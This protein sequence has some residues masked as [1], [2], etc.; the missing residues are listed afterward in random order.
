M[1][2]EIEQDITPANLDSTELKRI[3]SG[4]LERY[5][6]Y[7]RDRRPA[8]DQWLRNLRQYLGEYDPEARSQ[9]P[10]GKSKAYPK[11]TRMKVVGMVSK[12]MSM[13][14][15]EGE[16][17][18]SVEAS[19][20]PSVD[21]D[22]LEWIIGEWAMDNPEAQ[23]DLES[24]ES[25]IK[26]FADKAAERMTTKVRDQLNDA[27]EHGQI[28]YPT[29]ARKVV[30]SAVLYSM[31]VLKGPMTIESKGTR[32]SIND[33]NQVVISDETVYRPYFSFVRLWDYY[34]DMMAPSFDAMDGQF[35]R[36]IMSKHQLLRL[37][38]RD[39][40]MSDAI[41]EFVRQNP[42]GNYVAL[43]HE[44]KID[45]LENS[46]APGRRSSNKF[47]VVEYWGSVFAGDMKAMGEDIGSIK[48]DEEIKGTV[49]IVGETV[50]KA[51]RDPFPEGASMYHMFVFEHDDVNLCGSGLPP[52]M[53]DSQ[54]GASNA[55]RMMLDNAQSVCGPMTE[56]NVDLLMPGQTPNVA[57][58]Q[59]VYREGTGNEANLPVV[60]DLS[61]NSHLTELMSVFNQFKSLADEETFVN[62][63]TTGGTE[64][65]P[66]EAMRTQSNASMILGN[67]SL[68]FRDIVRNYDTFTV[69]VIH[70]LIQWNRIFDP[71]TSIDGDLRP[72]AKGSTSLMAKEVRS[73]A[74][75]NL[76]STITE[77]EKPYIDMGELAYARISV[78]DLP[79]KL[80]RP[81]E[82]AERIVEQ[83]QQMQQAMQQ[84][85][86]Q[87]QQAEV[88]KTNAEAA[89]DEAAA[90]ENEAEARTEQAELAKSQMEL[91]GKRI[92]AGADMQTTQ[93]QS[94]ASL[95]QS[96]ADIVEAG[97][98]AQGQ[99]AQ[100]EEKT[101]Q[102]V[103]SIL[104]MGSTPGGGENEER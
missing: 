77:D 96:Q 79:E 74:L 39:D 3:G 8:E 84:L 45:A 60:R 93:A 12:L 102:A 87:Q 2:D 52:I 70:S 15:P 55:A 59:V 29:L 64:G 78:R 69:S 35:Q 40:F 90:E 24:L 5:T 98:N 9:I 99:R 103:Q 53:R 26:V 92:E 36:H 25:E 89:K 46:H 57:P 100:A 33:Q 28:D 13:L 71:E 14:F 91:E 22:T 62:A 73:Y 68:P 48:E 72:L 66:G 54:M 86:Q 58:F 80:R 81:K 97:A 27:A 65:I 61:F 44:S 18:W 38:K 23:I 67:A 21:S 7:K 4:L 50:I 1:A 20:R 32:Y 19:A 88:R 85:G 43:D 56:V 42:E 41:R 101:A 76:A 63:T 16:D 75:D 51:A 11:L 94:Q 31:G 34:P 17:N 104:Q 83:N 10:E 95:A 37:A 30:Q 82:Q 47:E 6:Q 49:W